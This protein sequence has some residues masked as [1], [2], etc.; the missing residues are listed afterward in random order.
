[1]ARPFSDGDVFRAVADPIRRRILELLR[2]R[3]R[4][5]MQLALAVERAPATVS[6]HLRV[7]RKLGLVAVKQ[8]GRQFIYRVEAAQLK[9]IASWIKPFESASPARRVRT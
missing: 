9:R 8:D 4:S 3:D 5:P 7:L 1:M 2:V 6:E